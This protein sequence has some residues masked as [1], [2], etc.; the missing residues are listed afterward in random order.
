[1]AFDVQTFKTR[2][3]TAL[4]FGAVMLTGLLY[5]EWSF[6]ALFLLVSIIGLYE[7]KV[8]IMKMFQTSIEPFQLFGYVTIGL[9]I[10]AT[11]FFMP[12]KNVSD[13]LN[14]KISARCMY[15]GLGLLTAH[16][17]INYKKH[18]FPYAMGWA[19]I[20]LSLAMLGQVRHHAML[21]P[22]ALILLIWTN[23]T[24]Q[25]LCGSFF[26]KHKMS[27]TIS[28]KKTW[29]GTIGGSI[30]AII[31][32]CVWGYFSHQYRMIDWIMIGLIASIGGTLGD[33]VESKLK[34]MA[35]VKDSGSFMP[36][37]GGVLDR[38]DSL[39]F[40]APLLFVYETIFM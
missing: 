18:F 4:I 31:V 16:T 38:F 15:I 21:L 2:L 10:Y 11:V 25:Y 5:N 19:Y 24:M 34:R 26:G 40:C 13:I 37:H 14:P 23:D 12:I 32:A 30:I 28:P 35:D 17:I 39:L 6:F 22:I 36:G 20:P 9:L 8:I 29:E 3:T 27:P 1:M 33:L 7:Y